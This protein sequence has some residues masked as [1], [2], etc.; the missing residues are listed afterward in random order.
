MPIIKE[1][2]TAV[3]TPGEDVDVLVT[4]RGIAINPKRTDLLEK[5]QGSKLPICTIE[6]LL[7]KAYDITGVP[8]RPQ[9]G[10]K[11]V[12]VVVYRDGTVIDTIYKI[13]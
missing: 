10:S 1:K 9:K 4:E 7:E 8:A 11:P 6:Q 12:G 13:D 2:V 3:T 5:L